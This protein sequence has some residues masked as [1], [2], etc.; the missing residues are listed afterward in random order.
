MNKKDFTQSPITKGAKVDT[1]EATSSEIEAINKFTLEDLEEEDVFTFKMKIS[2]NEVDRTH[3]AFTFEALNEMKDLY[4]GKTLITDH[5]TSANN[6]IGRIY[7]TEVV[8]NEEVMTSTG[9]PYAELIGKAYVLNIDK[10]KDLIAEIKGGIK[11]EVSLSVLISEYVCAICNKDNTDEVCTHLWG[12][13]YD[14]RKCYF[15]LGGVK[16]A[17]EVSFV[18]VP[19]NKRAGTIRK[20]VE[21]AGVD[22]VSPEKKIEK[23]AEAEVL[24]RIMQVEAELFVEKEKGVDTYE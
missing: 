13:E 15:S 11:K 10:N 5:A 12:R 22:N 16:E 3:E 4:V 9:E 24:A 1:I 23:Q 7:D 20:M 14:G 19:A 17:H 8:V 6:Q 18:A 2:D 21:A